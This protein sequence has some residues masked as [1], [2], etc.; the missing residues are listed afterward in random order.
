MIKRYTIL[1]ILYFILIHPAVYPQQMGPGVYTDAGKRK[2][3]KWDAAVPLS[4]G[5]ANLLINLLTL[6][7][8]QCRLG[9]GPPPY[10]V[11]C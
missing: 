4:V 2:L 11:T 3:R 9:R 5:G 7:L 1:R 8:T 6:H 10:Q